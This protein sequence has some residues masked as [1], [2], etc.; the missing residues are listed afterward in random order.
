VANVA[1]KKA[2]N[3]AVKENNINW[4]EY[5]ASIVSV[6]PWSKAYWSKQ[7][8]DIC[9]W[10]NE[11]KQ[12]GDYVARVYTY[13]TASDYKLNKLMK[14]FNKER[15]DEEWLYSHP[16]HG[17]HSTPIPVLIQQDFALLSKIREGL[18]R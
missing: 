11:I 17:G 18:K 14:Q 10:T 16:K 3:V 15:E 4:A 6:C 5:F 13:P 7:K 8:I 12:L 1:A 9:D 2:A